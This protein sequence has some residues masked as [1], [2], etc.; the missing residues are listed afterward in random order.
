MIGWSRSPWT[1]VT[2]PSS[3]V[4]VHAHVSGQSWGQAPRT[5][6]V[7]SNGR[8]VVLAGLEVLALGVEGEEGVATLPR[9][10]AGSMT[11]ST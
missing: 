10:S 2:T 7:V 9:V 8:V 6:I 5:S 1:P 4:A 11:A 3:T